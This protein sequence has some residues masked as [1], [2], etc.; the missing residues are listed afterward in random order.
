MR[1]G[2]CDVTITDSTECNAAA[3]ALGVSD[4]TS[5]TD[6]WTSYPPGCVFRISTYG[7]DT[8][9]LYPSTNTYSCS[10]SNHDVTHDQSTIEECWANDVQPCLELQQ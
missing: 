6:T 2:T 10:S 8:L 5:S 1:T 9:M 3:T 4:T 7:S